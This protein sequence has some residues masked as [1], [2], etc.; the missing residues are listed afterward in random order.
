MYEKQTIIFKMRFSAQD[1]NALLS[2]QRESSARVAEICC[3]S[4][5]DLHTRCWKCLGRFMDLDGKFC[6]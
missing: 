2:D 3:R 6:F 4:F 1:A 5:A